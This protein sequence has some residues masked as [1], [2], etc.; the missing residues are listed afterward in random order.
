MA[1]SS[2][3]TSRSSYA[4]ESKIDPRP[5]AVGDATGETGGGIAGGAAAGGIAGAGIAGAGISGGGFAGA[6]ITGGGIS[7]GG[8]AGIAGAGIAGGGISGGGTAGIAG[9]GIAG[10]GTGTP[11]GGGGDL[12]SLHVHH[13]HGLQTPTY[14]PCT[15]LLLHT[16]QE[17][18]LPRFDIQAA[19]VV[20]AC[21]CPQ[22]HS[23]SPAALG[24]ADGDG[25]AMIDAGLSSRVMGGMGF[26]G[27]C[28]AIRCCHEPGACCCCCCCCWLGC[29]CCCC[30]C[31]CCWYC[32][33]FCCCCCCWFCW[34]HMVFGSG[35]CTWTLWPGMTSGGHTTP[36]RFPA[37]CTTNCWPG[38]TPGGTT[39]T[40]GGMIVS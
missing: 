14:S 39:T 1:N 25:A 12:H 36:M 31:C 8:T 15:T 38:A 13:L 7:G 20:R 6:G 2:P 37:N 3:I 17:P 4:N 9:A 10:G 28:M 22:R 18:R 16:S 26:L 35:A 23:D 40:I 33:C 34:C 29:C 24:G 19:I 27:A 11:A 5:G 32:C 30:C 21:P